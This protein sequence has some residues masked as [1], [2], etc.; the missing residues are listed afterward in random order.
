MCEEEDGLR[1]SIALKV[2]SGVLVFLTEILIH[3][4]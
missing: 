2:G 1:P 3:S 4:S